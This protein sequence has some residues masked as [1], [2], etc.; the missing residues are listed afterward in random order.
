MKLSLA[1]KL[2]ATMLILSAPLVFGHAKNAHAASIRALTPPGGLERLEFKH[3][4]MNEAGDFVAVSNTRVY[5]GNAKDGTFKLLMTNDQ[6]N[7]VLGD[8]VTLN[9][10]QNTIYVYQDVFQTRLALNNNGDFILASNNLLWLGNTRTGSIRQ[11]ANGGNFTS[12]QNVL[13]NDSGYY[14]AMG[15]KKLFGGHVAGAE[16]NQLLE[17]AAG[18]F[19]TLYLYSSFSD[20]R[21]YNGEH[22]AALNANGRFIAASSSAVYH[23]NVTAGPATLLLEERWGGFRHVALADDDTFSFVSDN[24]VYAGNLAD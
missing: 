19:A 11:I 6:A 3:H 14:F 10:N 8:M 21:G 9:N 7:F 13:I 20:V 4:K 12:F 5:A 1:A 18:N 16:A 17:N 23:G 2:T 15:Y 24:D 22:R